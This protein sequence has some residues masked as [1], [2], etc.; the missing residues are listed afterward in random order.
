MKKTCGFL[1]L[2]LVLGLLTS[3][4]SADVMYFTD[5]GLPLDDSRIKVGYRDGS[6]Y[7]I[8]YGDWQYADGHVPEGILAI[9]IGDIDTFTFGNAYIDRKIPKGEYDWDWPKSGYATANGVLSKNKPDET[10]YAVRVQMTGMVPGLLWALHVGHAGVNYGEFGV[11]NNKTFTDDTDYLYA[12]PDQFFLRMTAQ[13]Q[14]KGAPTDGTD[15]TIAA[16]NIDLSDIEV[17]GSKTYEATRESPYEGDDWFL[18]WRKKP[19]EITFTKEAILRMPMDESQRGDVPTI[20]SDSYTLY[21]MDPQIPEDLMRVRT[22]GVLE[23]NGEKAYSWRT[24]DSSEYSLEEAPEG[25]FCYTITPS[26]V[27]DEDGYQYENIAFFLA[28]D[29]EENNDGYLRAYAHAVQ[30]LSRNLYLFV[31][32]PEDVDVTT[33]SDIYS[34]ARNPDTS[35]GQ[36]S[37]LTSSMLS[38]FQEDSDK[39]GMEAIGFAFIS[40]DEVMST[41][42]TYQDK[43][44]YSY[45]SSFGN[46]PLGESRDYENLS[47]SKDGERSV[48][49]MKVTKAL[50]LRGDGTTA[51]PQTEA[52]EPT[53]G[54]EPDVTAEEVSPNESVGQIRIINNSNVRSGPSADYAQVG[55][56]RVGEVYEVVEQD[57]TGWYA[58]VMTDGQTGYVSP[59][60]VEFDGAR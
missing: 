9:E 22:R 38:K 41:W 10:L 59:K 34:M 29:D 11:Q 7:E 58:F 3:I 5:P 60:M 42:Y 24:L 44:Y 16:M 21:F 31:A 17:G 2:I 50:Q 49:F 1:V 37:Y 14:L 6:S 18:A 40:G 55:K 57:A 35:E 20:K 46:I 52:K 53:G 47:F 23:A 32:E 25:I 45:S 19:L 39:P 54:G 28:T 43:T 27:E 26:V 36:S 15:R 4:A 12:A 56:V 51:A 8:L 30:T 33:I 13:Q 48:T